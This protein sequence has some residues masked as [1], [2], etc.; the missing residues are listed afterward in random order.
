[1][2]IEAGRWKQYPLGFFRTSSGVEEARS[3]AISD[4]VAEGFG[5]D[6]P[7]VIFM[8]NVQRYINQGPMVDVVGWHVR[9]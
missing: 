7:K 6:H 2:S 3:W 8:P 9:A 4:A 1:M 5:N